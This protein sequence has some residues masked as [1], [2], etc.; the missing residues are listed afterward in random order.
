MSAWRSIGS[1]WLLC[2]GLA[3]CGSARPNARDAADIEVLR[4]RISKVRGAIDETRETIIRSQGTSY[5]A[6]LYLRLAELLSEEAKYH[7]QI[8]LERGQGAA[9]DALHVPQVRVR[10]EQAIGLY[11]KLLREYPKSSVAP[12]AQYN[13]AMEYRELGEFE[14]MREALRE[15]VKNQSE[16][17]L[18]N[19]AFILLGDYHFDKGELVKARNYYDQVPRSRLGRLTGLAQWKT[20]WVEVNL[21]DCK[22]ALVR[23]ERAIHAGAAY[24]SARQAALRRA[25][26]S[27]AAQQEAA[28]NALE[29]EDDGTYDEAEAEEGDEAEAKVD[30]VEQAPLKERQLTAS[31]LAAEEE[32]ADVVSGGDAVDVRRTALIDLVYCY[33]QE[34]KPKTVLP[35]LRRL[36][37]D[38]KAYVAALEKLARRYGFMNDGL[39]SIIV[40]RE[41]LKLGPVAQDRI[42]EARQ[43]FGALRSTKDYKR[44]GEDVALM[45]RVLRRHVRQVDIEA[46]AE[47]SLKKE[48]E[49]YARDLLTRAQELAKKAPLRKQRRLAASVAEGYA[50]YLTTFP[51]ADEAGNMRLNQGDAWMLAQR[52]LL[53]AMA[54]LGAADE[55]EAAKGQAKKAPE[56]KAK[57]ADDGEEEVAEKAKDAKKQVAKTPED[58]AKLIVKTYYTSTVRFQEALQGEHAVERISDRRLARAELRRAGYR[59]LAL[60]GGEDDATRKVKFAIAQSYYDEGA[61]LEAIDRL[62]AVAYEYPGSIESNAAI[63]LVLDSYNTLNDFQGLTAAGKRYLAEGSPATPELRAEIKPILESSEQRVLDEV[64][65]EAAGDEGGDLSALLAFAESKAGTELGERALLNAFLAARAMGDS[66]QLYRL[67]EELAKGYP[68]SEQLPGILSTLGQS[69][70]AR[71]EFDKATRF[72]EKAAATDHPQKVQLL[73]AGA[74]IQEALGRTKKAEEAYQKALALGSG[75]GQAQPLQKLVSLYE[76]TGQRDA[77]LANLGPMA[78]RGDMELNAALGLAYLEAGNRDQAERLLEGVSAAGTSASPDALAKAQYGMAELTALTLADYPALTDPMQLEEYL[79][80]VEV[81]QQAY[82]NAARQGVPD[83]IAASLLRLASLSKNAGTRLRAAPLTQGLSGEEAKAVKQALEGRAK[84]LEDTALQALET[85]KQQAWSVPAFTP[86]F[87]AC[88]KGNTSARP[89]FAGDKVSAQGRSASARDLEQLRGRISRDPEDVEALRE[90]SERFAA[91]GDD[92]SAVLALEAALK[93]SSSPGDANDLGLAYA[94]MGNTAGALESFARAASGGLEAGRRNLASLLQRSGLSSAAAEVDKRYPKGREGGK[95]LG[96]GP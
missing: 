8:A 34:R 3:A 19:S 79:A 17:P 47:A 71:F 15:M 78:N 84:Q 20:A 51:D 96:E 90:L 2:A 37:S 62:N 57:E 23:F 87:R 9:S 45:L 54:T 46:E 64:S 5:A 14:K 29:V 75:R 28:R 58:E 63:R 22:K 59:W 69:A 50:A 25:V 10:K 73:V 7:Y 42:E 27:E 85:C 56:S 21:G 36:A 18:R 80:I 72:L 60:G 94:R 65:L 91:A 6:E 11:R 74:E 4:L 93:V 16:S 76:R 1:A 33:S 83:Y 26:L 48:F 92:H 52:P 30:E 95:R 12:R 81:S 41:V 40:T 61:L 24:E 44:V 66:A 89:S 13:I 35:Y 77:L 68:K 82:A 43:L 32:S 39:G 88:F 49:V 67:G 38:R 70:A 31:D 55:L 53:A 86:V